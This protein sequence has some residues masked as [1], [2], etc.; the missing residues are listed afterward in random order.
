MRSTSAFLSPSTSRKMPAAGESSTQEISGQ[1]KPGWEFTL[2]QLRASNEEL[3]RRKMDAEKDRDLFRELYSKAS[4]HASEVSKEN[5]DLLERA[6]LAE[7]QVRDGLNMVKG[8]YE[9]QI[10]RL[11]EEVQRWK[12]LCEVL[13]ARDARMNDEIRR[14]AALEP[15]LTEENSRLREEVEILLQDSELGDRQGT[16]Q[17]VID[18]SE[19]ATV[20]SSSTE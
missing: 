7:G 4:A 13:T 8:M 9:E 2:E 18:V 19:T 5:N 12:G 6:I 15:E 20:V 1:S 16:A 14:R 10:R 11:E 3:Q 17:T